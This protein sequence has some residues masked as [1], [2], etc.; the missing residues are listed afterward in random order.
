MKLLNRISFGLLCLGLIA[1]KA[2]EKDPDKPILL[3]LSIEGRVVGCLAGINHLAIEPAKSS[4]NL[5]NCRRNAKALAVEADVTKPPKFSLNLYS[6]HH[7]EISV[8]TLPK[9]TTN[10]MF[11]ALE[12][13]GFSPSDMDAFKQLHPMASYRALTLSKSMDPPIE[14]KSNLD[15]ILLKEAVG[16][17]IKVIEL[18]EIGR[19]SCRER[20]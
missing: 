18:E 4:S 19:A 11:K 20:V 17:N 13:A 7:L 15:L 12:V 3:E 2:I 9:E 6:R 5:E 10:R 14:L 8:A 1:C 16:S